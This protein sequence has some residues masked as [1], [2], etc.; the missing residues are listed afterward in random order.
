EEANALIKGN[1]N[2]KNKILGM[3]S[4]EIRAPLKMMSMFIRRIAVRTKDKQ[5]TEYLKTMRFTNHSLLLQAN[6]ILEYTK[7]KGRALHLKPTRLNLSKEIDI[8]IKAFQPYIESKDN[9]CILKN[10]ID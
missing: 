9:K 1:L 2:F 10:T 8:L 5:I 7:N 3:L 4:H 6:Q